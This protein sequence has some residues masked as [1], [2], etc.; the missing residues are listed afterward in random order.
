MFSLFPRKVIPASPVLSESPPTYSDG[1]VP[2]DLSHFDQ[3]IQCEKRNNFD[4]MKYHLLKSYQSDNNSDAA[5]MLCKR[6]ETESRQ[7]LSLKYLNYAVTMG[8]SDALAHRIKYAMGCNII[9]IELIN[10]VSKSNNSILYLNQLVTMFELRRNCIELNRNTNTWNGDNFMQL[11][12]ALWQLLIS[13]KR[14]TMVDY[15]S[16]LLSKLITEYTE[17]LTGN[18]TNCTNV[19]TYSTVIDYMLSEIN[20]H[21][22]WMLDNGDYTIV[23]KIRDFSSNVLN[24]D[25]LFTKCCYSLGKLIDD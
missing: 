3:A 16:K 24:D 25:E 18:A 22:L 10:D 11:Y 12:T 9:T 20:Q 1:K 6:F 7:K 2:L 5:L 13:T 8:N 19:S 17:L 15:R 4:M 23:N 21:S 14:D